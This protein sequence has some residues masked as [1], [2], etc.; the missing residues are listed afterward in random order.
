MN[1]TRLPIE[2]ARAL[3]PALA[4]S[5]TSTAHSGIPQ[6]NCPGPPK[7][8]WFL[9]GELTNELTLDYETVRRSCAQA[10]SA[11]WSRTRRVASALLSGK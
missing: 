11:R 8:I 4:S 5:L 10:W 9:G 2:A 7:G 1:K 6:K 3:P